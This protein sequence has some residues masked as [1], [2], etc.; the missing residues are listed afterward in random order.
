MNTNEG[1][2]PINPS[3]QPD[4]SVQIPSFRDLSV[5]ESLIERFIQTALL[6]E[7]A[8]PI[9]SMLTRLFKKMSLELEHIHKQIAAIWFYQK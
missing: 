1:V 7:L 3:F 4:L 8:L 2:I 9:S 6:D 5:Y